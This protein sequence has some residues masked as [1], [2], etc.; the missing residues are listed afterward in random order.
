MSQIDDILGFDPSQLSVFNEPKSNSFVDPTIYKPNP[1]F[2]T[3]EDGVYRSKVR[4]ILNPLSPKDTIVP[5]AQYWLQSVDGSRPVFSSLSIGDKN[6]PIF[7]AW[8]SLWYSDDE[9]KK[10]RSRKI[11]QKNETQWVLVQI[12]EDKNQPELVGKFKVMKLAKDIY[13]KMVDLMNPSAE[14]GKTPYPVADYVVGLELS[15]VVQPGPDDPKAPER[16]QREISYTLSSFGSY[17]PVIKTDGTPLLTD[18]E[19]ELVDAYVTAKNDSVSGKTAKKRDEGAAKLAEL[20]PQLRPIYEKAIEYVKENLRDDHGDIIDLQK[21]CGYTPWD[22]ETTK[23]VD[24]WI[25][26]VKADFDPAKVS[27]HDLPTL[28]AAKAK[29]KPEAEEKVDDGTAANA[30]RTAPAEPAEDPGIGLPF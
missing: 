12:L 4:I 23:F 11:F 20:Q 14:S 17:A 27:Y 25:A 2:A 8:K 28:T 24:Q 7:K 1:K 19:I 3:S 22:E 18:D 6:C 10:E 30:E 5:Q 16:K 9:E 29:A 21:K 15:L 26:V 13:T